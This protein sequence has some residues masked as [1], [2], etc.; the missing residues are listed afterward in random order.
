MPSPMMPVT[1]T[2]RLTCRPE[3][4]PAESIVLPINAP[5][6]VWG[7]GVTRPG[8]NVAPGYTIP[9]LSRRAVAISHAGRKIDDVVVETGVMLATDQ[10]SR[11]STGGVDVYDD[12][13]VLMHRLSGAMQPRLRLF[14]GRYLLVVRILDPVCEIDLDFERAT[15][16]SL[17][18]PDP[19]HTRSAWEPAA[20][21]ATARDGQTGPLAVALIAAACVHVPE[22]RGDRTVSDTF[23]AAVK[24]LIGRGADWSRDMFKVRC[25]QQGIEVPAGSARLSYVATHARQLLTASQLDDVAEL[26]SEALGRPR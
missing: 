22:L 18:V 12:A 23:D 11:H 10:G 8:K 15:A 6:W 16:P 9:E 19:D 26:I 3:V 21:F 25:E 5:E 20:I 24:A 14:P 17:R 13:G 1:S 2:V 7:R 4:G